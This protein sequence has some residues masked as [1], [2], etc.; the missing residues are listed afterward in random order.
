[1]H[2][3]PRNQNDSVGLELSEKKLPEDLFEKL[4]QALAPGLKKNLGVEISVAPVQKPKTDIDLD[5]ISDVLT[6]DSSS[7]EEEEREEK[8]ALDA[9][10]SE[11][12]EEKIEET[13]KKVKEKKERSAKKKS[14]EEKNSKKTKKEPE[15][16]ESSEDVSIDDI[17]DLLR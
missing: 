16:S 5:K 7:E 15:E 2:I 12:P 11:E 13:V 1:L 9:E 8:N 17:A 3:I 10:E 4:R 14:P 6:K